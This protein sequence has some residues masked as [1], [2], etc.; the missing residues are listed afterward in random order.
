VFPCLLPACH[1]ICEWIPHHRAHP[2]PPSANTPP[3]FPHRPS[4]TFPLSLLLTQVSSPSCHST[5]PPP[6]SSI[7]PHHA[8]LPPSS[9]LP[10]ISNCCDDIPTISSLHH[11]QSIHPYG[12]LG[13][14]LTESRQMKCTQPLLLQKSPL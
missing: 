6:M 11:S 1:S 2:T 10:C 5:C 4:S 8:S 12:Q 9:A 13:L 7:C 14:R 3:I